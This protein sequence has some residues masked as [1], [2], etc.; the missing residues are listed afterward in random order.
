MFSSFVRAS[1]LGVELQFEHDFSS[2]IERFEP[3]APATL[4]G[5]LMMRSVLLL[6]SSR[7]TLHAR[8]HAECSA[9]RPS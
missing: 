8:N 9:R 2:V 4:A 3:A 6:V 1:S 5:N 7:A